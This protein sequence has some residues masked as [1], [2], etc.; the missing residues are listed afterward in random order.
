MAA[1]AT[2][3]QLR[4]EAAKH[5]AELEVDKGY[6]GVYVNAYAPGGKAWKATGGTVLSCF[7][8][9]GPAGWLGECY[10]DVWDRM[11]DGL[12]DATKEEES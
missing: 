3:A 11:R 1:T 8:Y 10:G 9:Y 5:G 6:D 2:L 4:R 7:T 12:V